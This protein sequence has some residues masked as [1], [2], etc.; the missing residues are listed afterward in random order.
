VNDHCEHN[1]NHVCAPCGKAAHAARHPQA[2]DGCVECK[3]ASIQVSPAV[4]TTRSTAEPKYHGFNNSWEKGVWTD[5]RGLPIRDANLE[6][7]PIKKYAENRRH[8]DA[9]RHRL[10]NHPD[11][12]GTGTRSV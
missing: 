12:F 3:L 7:I 6:P 8:Y 1:P 2:V 4:R 10:A 5:A 9:V 11:P